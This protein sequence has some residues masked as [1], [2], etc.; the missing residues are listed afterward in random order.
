MRLIFQNGFWVVHI[1]FFCMVKFKLLSQ[2][3]VDYLLYP[4]MSSLI[5]FGADLLHSRIMR[6][7]VSSLSSHN[8][9][10][11]FCCILSI[12]LSHRPYSIALCCFQQRFSFS[13]K[14]SLSLPFLSILMRDFV[15]LSLE[16]CIQLF[17]FLFLFSIYYCSVN[18]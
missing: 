4:I 7:I 16:V 5:L 12:L 1:S 13:F 17:F 2:F 6:L 15:C 11:L 10:Q 18:A 14:A 9:H 8:L 3:P